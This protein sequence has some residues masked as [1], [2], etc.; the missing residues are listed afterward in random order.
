MSKILFVSGANSSIGSKLIEKVIEDFDTVIAHYSHNHD[1][2][3]KLIS[4]NGNKIVP[5]QSDFNSRES[6]GNMLQLLEEKEI[7]PTHFV[8]LVASK[9]EY[10]K[11][12]KSNL[13]P[14]D[15]EMQTDYFSFIQLC[16]AF[17]PD[18]VK[19]RYGKI[20]VMLTAYTITSQ[21]NYMSDYVSSKFALLGLVKALASEYAAKGIRINGVSPEMINTK[22]IQ[23]LPSNVLDDVK[24]SRSSKRLLEVEDILPTIE[25]LLS[26]VSDSITGQNILIP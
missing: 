22:F 13:E 2:I 9:F 21:P 7:K 20:V 1:F 4:K 25:F 5:V 8:H 3:D 15:Q 23:A 26:E 10:V 12:I 11:F 16:Q 24:K 6:I 18:M 14:F 17:F 19:N